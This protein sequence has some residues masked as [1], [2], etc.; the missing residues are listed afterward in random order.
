MKR[1]ISVLLAFIFSAMLLQA[2]SVS[3]TP[4]GVAPRVAEEDT[5][6]IFDLPYDALLNVGVGTQMYLLGAVKDTTL[7]GSQSW[8]LIEAP[9]GSTITDLTA[10]HPMGDN[11][12]ILIFKPDVKGVFKIKFEYAGQSAEV[13]IHSGLFLGYEDGNCQLCH[14][15]KVN[16]W[17]ETGHASMLK[18]GLDGTLSDHYAS[19]CIKCHTVG[20]DPNADNDGFDDFDFTFP[21]SLFEGQYDNMVAT[22]PDAMKRANIQCESCHG[23]AN[24]HF[25]NASDNR[26]TWSLDVNTCA[27]CHDEG[28]HHYFPAQWRMSGHAAATTLGYA[29]GR[30]SCAQCHSGSGFIKYI[31]TGKQPLTEAPPLAKIGCAT[32]HDPHSVGNIHQLRTVD[33]VVLGNGEV[34]T[35][36][37]TGKL[38][39]NCHK[40]RRDA[41]LYTGEEFHYSSHYGPHH[42]PQADVLAATNA[43]D[44]GV[45]L[46]SSPHLQATEDA[47]VT[48]HMGPGQKPEGADFPI[49]GM[50]TFSVT[51]PDGNDNVQICQGCHGDFGPS[52]GDK[53]FFMNGVGD[54]DGD[55]V[56]EGLQHEVEGLL[57]ELALLLPPYD[58]LDVDV[59][60]KYDYSVVERKAAFNYLM[61]EEDRSKGVHNPAFVVSLLKL[62]IAAVKYGQ[63]GPGVI[64]GVWDVPN[65]QGNMV[66]VAWTKFGGDGIGMPQINQYG[67]WRLD[68]I[69]PTPPAEI[70][71][72]DQVDA[73]S[74]QIGDQ[75]MDEEFILTYVAYV[76]AANMPMYNVNVPTLFNTVEGDTAWTG[77][78]VSGIAGPEVIWSKPAFGF[79]VDNLVP[80]PP[81]GFAGEANENS[82]VLSWLESED[83]DFDYFAIYRSETANFDPTGMTPYG[84]TSGTSFVD[85]SVEMGKTYYYKLAVVDFN[86]NQSDYSPELAFTITGV[87]DEMG[88]PT[89]YALYQNYPNPFNPSTEIKFA[90]PETANITVK[91]YNSLGK[92]IATIASGEY[93]AGYHRI[94]WD[95]KDFATGVYFCELKTDK[96]TQVNKMML[97]K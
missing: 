51:D 56:V 47:C 7:D 17:K 42:G 62:S 91:I 67:V 92:E 80:A 73:S 37:G 71:S 49:S 29:G 87:E 68:P 74:L 88:I 60:G 48:C 90:L 2:Q 33:D 58:T 93:E 11:G 65:D 35:A 84:T 64:A 27:K 15:S 63:L 83:V 30:S 72:K 25:G 38:C 43:A 6:D 45:K 86:K 95:A 77:F 97:M 3:L 32:C 10:T 1:V 12:E 89:K 96:F 39:M 20:Y 66:N 81:A 9:D 34:I 41:K 59:S 26:M 82:I 36:G 75:L 8:S 94:Y 50:H 54:H 40:G 79:S 55:G 76:P 18:R 14:P 13:S 53:I 52:F 85:N 57:E 19:Y 78:V 24:D 4:Y 70:K 5:A 61:V 44:F 16:E 69:P 21:D 28:T 23:P 46:P 22:Y 31:E